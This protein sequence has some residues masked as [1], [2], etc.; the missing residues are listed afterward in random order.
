M[1]CVLNLYAFFTQNIQ[2]ENIRWSVTSVCIQMRFKVLRAVG[3]KSAIFCG[4]ML[5]SLVKVYQ[6]S[7]RASVN[8]CETTQH[9]TAENRT[10]DSLWCESLESHLRRYRDTDLKVHF[11]VEEC[12][13]L[14]MKSALGPCLLGIWFLFVSKI[15][16]F[17]VDLIIVSRWDIWFS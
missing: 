14:A 3:V 8:F 6:D 12:I 11:C 10:L 7:S 5:C 17:N 4:V 2:N 1:D 13:V 16:S 9:Q 15:I